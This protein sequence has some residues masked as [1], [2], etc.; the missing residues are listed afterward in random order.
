MILDKKKLLKEGYLLL[1]GNSEPDKIVDLARQLGEVIKHP[2]GEIIDVIKPHTEQSARKGSFSYNFGLNEFPMH[3][4]TSFW[5]TPARYL[6]FG[7]KEKSKVSTTLTR[8]SDILSSLPSECLSNI[9]NCIYLLQTYEETKYVGLTFKRGGQ[10]GYRFDPN[11]MTP[12][13]DVAKIVH[14]AILKALSDLPKIEINWVGNQVAIVDNWQFL[15]GRNAVGQ[16][17]NNRELLRLYV[18]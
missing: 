17:E 15:H 8:M 18:R 5:S 16:K 11:I 13:N 12:K 2:N 3:T 6:I 4:D 10:I 14:E 9:E 7:M 1:D